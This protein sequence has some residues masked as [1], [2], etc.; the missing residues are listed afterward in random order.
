MK[1]HNC[2]WIW[3]I[4][5]DDNH[6]FLCHKC[7][8]DSELGDFN[9]VSFNK[10]KKENGYPF[11]EYIEEGFHI[12]TFFN[13]I[14]NTELVWHRD[15]EDRIVESIGDTDW[16]I[17]LDNELPKQLTEKIFIPKETFHRVIK[18]NGDLKVRVKK[19]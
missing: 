3:K 16:M 6:P 14:D 13:N 17:Q 15:K 8:Y 10:W 4:E 11:T 2:S 7:G 12:R 19:L 18:G 9:M 5:K 1:C